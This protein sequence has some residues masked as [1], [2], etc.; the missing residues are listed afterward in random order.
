[1]R[2][3]L[4]PGEHYIEPTAFGNWV[5]SPGVRETVESILIAVLL[6]LLFRYFEAEA[7]VIPTG[8]MAP[9]LQGQHID[10]ACPQCDF[11]YRAGASGD[12]PR[13]RRVACPIC[14][15]PLTLQT[16]S[17]RDHR[18]FSG[19]RILVNK[20]AYDFDD[21]DRWD[22]IVFKY[23]N[24]GKQNFIKRLIGLP[25]EGILIERGDIYAF[26]RRN[27]TFD[28]RAIARK[29][30]KKLKSMLQLVDDTN[31]I[32]EALI[33]VG[34]PSRW[35]QWDSTQSE[36]DWRIS[37]ELNRFSLEESGKGLK[38]LRYRHLQPYKSEWENQLGL[39]EAELPRRIKEGIPIG[40]LITDHYAYNDTPFRDSDT[41]SDRVGL[42]WVGDLS[43]RANVQVQSNE[44]ELVLELV[45][46]KVRFRCSIDVSSGQATFSQLDSGD[47]QTVQLSAETTHDTSVKGQGSYTIQF[48]NADD[49]LFLWVDNRF[50]AGCE[51][52]RTDPVFPTWTSEDAGDAEP[53]GIGG[54][55]ITLEIDRL[56][57]ERDIYYTSK[58]LTK[59]R[60]MQ[61]DQVPEIEYSGN[62]TPRVIRS[63]LRQPTRWN[64]DDA[65]Q[66]FASRARDESYVF[67]L[68][69]NQLLPMGDN[70]PQSNDARIWDGA[71]YIDSSYLLGEALFIYWPHAKTSPL[72][73]WPNFGQMKFIR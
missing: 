36:S 34:W 28:D 70:S 61:Y 41:F 45:E 66:M 17:R 23:P 47:D 27:E 63:L 55:N 7:Y 69:E 46:G 32:P 8:S 18:P 43:V 62:F 11:N 21:P 22:V 44:G 10:V 2:Q 39:R 73:F 71:R 5:R 72:P 1:M 31:H 48:A 52:T 29:S 40:Q 33:A 51:Y 50:V 16:A 49:K 35:Q 57:V 9:D 38:W 6:A 19:D 13:V 42:H 60:G 64:E 3:H 67:P 54:R 58:N 30:P 14:Q 53:V 65:R 37:Q 25:N 24:N 68:E 59:E 56:V 20:F 15:F 12:S 4:S 26:D